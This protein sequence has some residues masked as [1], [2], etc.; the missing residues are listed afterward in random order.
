MLTR[1]FF[2]GGAF[3]FGAFLREPA[4]AALSDF[5]TR[6]RGKVRF[7]VVSDIHVS[8]SL[9]DGKTI[10]KGPVNALRRA[11]E[12]FRDAQVDAVVIP[13]DLAMFGTVA[14]LKTIANVWNEVFPNGRRPDGEKVERVFVMGNHDSEGWL[15]NKFAETFIPDESVRRD[16]LLAYDVKRHWR[17]TFDEDFADFS[18]KTVKGYSFV[19][20][21]W[22]GPLGKR[23]CVGGPHDCLRGVKAFYES[24]RAAFDPRRPFFHVQHPTPKNTCYGSVCWG[25]DTGETGQALAAFPNAIALSGHCHYSVADERA[26]WQGAYTSVSCGT[27]VSPSRDP[28][29]AGLWPSGKKSGDPFS[30]ENRGKDKGPMGLVEG[31]GEGTSGLIVDVYDDNV[32]ISRLNLPHGTTPLGDDWVVPLADERPFAFAS[33]AKKAIAPEFPKGAKVT[34]AAAVASAG[35]LKGKNVVSIRFPKADAAKGARVYEYA[36]TVVRPNGERQEKHVLAPGYNGPVDGKHASIPP[37]CELAL[38]SVPDW[39]KCRFEV[40]ALECFGKAGQAI[41]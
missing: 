36:V 11:F 3:A 8:L 6:K 37:H 5:A 28:I 32:R 31:N 1:R 22:R 2:I 38:E 29:R 7:G 39:E 14:E 12:A 19:Q 35:P 20:A 23:L 26:I 13:G 15:Y 24:K 25:H 17:E 9:K 10:G 27:L 40:R 21:H 34:V 4:F 41:F 33:R 18:I 30:F 16:Q